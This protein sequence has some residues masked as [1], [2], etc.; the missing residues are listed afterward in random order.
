MV[1][2]TTLR[3]FFNGPDR[4]RNS[5][6]IVLTDFKPSRYANKIWYDRIPE[7]PPIVFDKMEGSSYKCDTVVTFDKLI[8]AQN[9]MSDSLLRY[10][11]YNRR[12]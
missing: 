8:D 3:E 6:F 7:I 2:R 12:N 11:R 9:S 1:S 5:T 4:F 10:A